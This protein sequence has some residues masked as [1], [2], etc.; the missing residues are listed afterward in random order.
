MNSTQG[1]G[2]LTRAVAQSRRALGGLLERVR[3]R[4]SGAG[5]S[6]RKMRILAASQSYPAM[7]GRQTILGWPFPNVPVIIPDAEPIRP[8]Y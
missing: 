2:G 6:G 4:S 7:K 8:Q 3:G 5:A 1:F